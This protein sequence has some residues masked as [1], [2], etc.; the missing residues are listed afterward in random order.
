MPRI[1][2]IKMDNEETNNSLKT[3]DSDHLDYFAIHFTHIIVGLLLLSVGVITL[4]H[5]DYGI[6]NFL[7]AVPHFFLTGLIP[8]LLSLLLLF[9]VFT[10]AEKVSISSSKTTLNLNGKWIK[11]KSLRYDFSSIQY[12]G[13]KYRETRFKRWSIVALLVLLTIEVHWQNAM[14]LLGHARIAP[15]L[16]ICT[17]LLS[18]AIVLF[19]SFPRRFIE[20]GTNDNTILIPYR[21]LS[22]DKQIQ[23]LN[24]L[25]LSPDHFYRDK[26]I[27]ILYNNILD[28]FSSFLMGVFLMGF[29]IVLAL[30][31]A[32]FYGSFTRT[33]AI[34]LGMKLI[35]RVLNGDPFYFKSN[36]KN[37]Y[38]GRSLRLTF[39]KTV[40]ATTK[41]KTCFSPLR[42][43]FLEIACFIYLIFQSIRYSFRNIW[44][45]YM[46]FSVLYFIIGMIIIGF[47]FIRWIT[48]INMHQIQ[49]DEYS[50]KI[51]NMDPYNQAQGGR[52]SLKLV[53]INKI[54]SFIS[55]L[56]NMKE[57]R[58]QVISL[59]IFVLFII[60]PIIYILFG[61]NF[62]II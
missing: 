35:L 9:R 48:P 22:K 3:K 61:G 4:I 32:I 1:R 51:R 26:S 17:V 11:R 23:L 37:L 29:G 60:W 45:P 34:V 7:F 15:I 8:T 42:Y 28:G 30:T 31:P 16:F 44:Y 25:K 14:D 36:E 43:H 41:V 52:V 10:E 27:T 19:V 5:Y 55:N 59:G 57:N 38:I 46:T 62:L 56:K 21:I 47:I 13:L 50:I 2:G 18:I 20:I 6:I 39:I 40:D 54:K 24:L 12:V 53:I 58:L 33:I 49:F